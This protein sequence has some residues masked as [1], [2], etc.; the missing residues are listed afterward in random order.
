MARP[1]TITLAEAKLVPPEIGPDLVR[2]LRLTRS[3]DGPPGCVLSLVTAPAGYGKTTAVA[4]WLASAGIP[5]AWVTCDDGENDPVRLWSYVATAV[6]R[7]VPGSG[8]AALVPGRVGAVE[9]AIDELCNAL[10]RAGASVAIVLDDFQAVT[11]TE[12]VRSVRYLVDRL[13]AGCRLVLVGRTR[14]AFSLARLRA[15]GGLTELS[16]PELAFSVGEARRLLVGSHGDGPVSTT[17]AE[18][19]VD[20]MQGWPVGIRLATLWLRSVDDPLNAVDGLG[21]HPYLSEYLSDE[22][23]GSLA[24]E[25]AGFLIRAA[26]LSPV[27]GELC[28]D[29]LGRSDSAAML[30]ELAAADIFLMPHGRTGWYAVHAVFREFA[31][32]RLDADAPDDKTRL[33]ELAAKWARDRGMVDQALRYAYESGRTDLVSEIL[34]DN[35]LALLRSNAWRTLTYWAKLV[36]S[37]DLARHPIVAGAAA[38]AAGMSGRSGLE[39]QRLSRVALDG[40]SHVSRGEQEYIEAGMYL[41]SAMTLERGVED[42]LAAARRAVDL[43]Q[44]SAPEL[45]TMALASLAM[46]QYF[47]GDDDDA[48]STCLRILQHPQVERRPLGRALARIVLSYVATARDQLSTARLHADFAHDILRRG[49]GSRSWFGANADIAT[50]LIL[51]HDDQL[52]TATRELS[53][54]DKFLRD[55][56]PSLHHARLMALTAHVRVRRGQL[57]DARIALET[58]RTELQEFSTTGIVAPLVQATAD[59]LD[60]AGRRLSSGE[61]LSPPSAAELTVLRLLVTDLSARQIA[62]T[63]LLSPNTVNTHIKSL[64]R[65]LGVRTR[66][67]AV[68]RAVILGTVDR[69]SVS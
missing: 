11:S 62:A 14:P 69:D 59:E 66:A 20:R 15:A 63:L 34:S 6:D 18:R 10:V 47:S 35:H 41:L 22:V 57:A 3:L 58:A 51:A 29:V 43:T 49:G 50:A 40:S 1:R 45:E 31:Q 33:F 16:A 7:A 60:E 12:S 21:N 9:A 39:R 28:D 26:A 19:L 4:Q 42:G 65:K 8:R 17:L 46:A 2:R 53:A 24:P 27:S 52:T 23:L 44:E 64:Y 5:T 25:Q 61:L 13:P 37:D 32:A 48:T 68:A 56:V 36:G 30:A 38:F 55:E 54:A 67:D